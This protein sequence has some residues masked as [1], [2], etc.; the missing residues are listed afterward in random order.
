MMTSRQ[1]VEAALR[2]ENSD[3]VPLDL[4][5]SAVTGMHVS[6][7]HRLR[8]A[9]GL[10][11][12]ERPVKVIE[13]FQMLGEIEPDL[14]EALGVDVVGVGG[15]R[16][17]F[18]FKNENWKPWTLLDGTPVLVPEAFNTVPESNGDVLMYP[19]G[20]K[21]APPSGRMP[22]G[23][24]YFDAIVRQ[25]PINDDKLDVQDN[26]EE[27][28]PISDDDLDY[29]RTETE[30]L[31]TQTD[32]AILAM[33]GGTS[34]GD[35]ACVPATQLK[36]PKGIRDIAEWYLSTV[37]RRDYVYEVFDKQCSIA[38]QNLEKIYCAVGDQV[39]VAFITGT[40]FGAQH[41]SFI[42]LDAYRDLYKPFHKRINDWVHSHTGWKTF[43]HS[44]GSMTSFIEDVIEA[45]FDILNPVQTSAKGMDPK[46]LKNQ[47]GDRIV[48]WGGGIDTQ[49]T[50]PFG[51]PQE[52]RDEVRERIHIFGQDGGFVFNTVHNV[53]AGIPIDNL[54]ALYKAV[55]E[56]R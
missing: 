33:F 30:R 44:C 20:D 34:F 22:Y 38:L 54:V 10:N 29:F 35:I 52:I 40:D 41:G 6:S 23:G 21:S 19:E 9:L 48:F 14:L 51:A 4:G 15:P 18:G 31:Y 45:G 24:L 42:S 1:R 7:V 11:E 16:T 8:L 53:Q 47:F 37:T 17:F 27:F 50:L 3:C 46:Q 32:K 12:P 5:G 43:M 28:G 13:P 36:H 56:F 49:R 39:S 26:L 25:L 55:S 2:H